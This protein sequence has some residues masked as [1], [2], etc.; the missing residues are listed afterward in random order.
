MLARRTLLA[1]I[2]GGLV[3]A[4]TA[5]NAQAAPV[6]AGEGPLPDTSRTV[7]AMRRSLASPAAAEGPREMQYYVVRRRY[8]VR[9]YYV[10]RRRFA[11]NC[12]WNGYGRVCR[13]RYF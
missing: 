2:G 4:A 11:W 13:W 10:R 12:W 1:A 8:W 9:R 6:V 5:L 7:A 3:V